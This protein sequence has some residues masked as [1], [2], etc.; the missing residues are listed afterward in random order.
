MHSINVL[1]C[2][3]EVGPVRNVSLSVKANTIRVS[4]ILPQCAGNIVEIKVQYKKKG[5]SSWKLEVTAPRPSVTAILLKGLAYQT[6]YEVRI[7]V[8]DATS[9]VHTTQLA[10]TAKIGI[11]TVYYE[12]LLFLY[13]L[14]LFVF[15]TSA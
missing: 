9:R 8:T 14:L 11:S 13:A 6:E 1:L 3:L 15:S 10:K 5:E 7:N 2:I 4:W 12:L